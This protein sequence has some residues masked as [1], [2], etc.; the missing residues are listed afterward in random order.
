[1]VD[2]KSKAQPSSI[3]TINL[4]HQQRIDVHQTN[5]QVYAQF[6]K[7]YGNLL[8]K[9]AIWAN[10]KSG[11]RVDK[12]DAYQ[13]VAIRALEVIRSDRCSDREKLIGFVVQSVR[14]H[15][16]NI[17][18]GASSGVKGRS[19]LASAM[20]PQSNDSDTFNAND[21]FDKALNW[22]GAEE[23]GHPE[24]RLIARD[25]LDKARLYADSLPSDERF[26]TE[27][28]VI[29]TLVNP[30]E[31]LL[32]FSKMRRQ[33]QYQA[34]INSANVIDPNMSVGYDTVGFEVCSREDICEYVGV[35]DRTLYR[36]VAKL[37]K[38]LGVSNGRSN[39]T[40]EP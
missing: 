33:E 40:T 5:E 1:M 37:A 17:T 30:S 9:L 4:H 13:E 23:D 15:A 38:H 18:K 26:D 12:D 25:L 34:A 22:F 32:H 20:V 19:T 6:I 21:V 2:T 31:S 28:W 10:Q 16:V 3:S 29:Q 39:E 35:S 8:H 11:G 14:N 36:V 24:R 7:R 27:R